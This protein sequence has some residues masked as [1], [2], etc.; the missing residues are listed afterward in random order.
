MARLPVPLPTR[1]P[2]T[3]GQ[4]AVAVL[5][6]VVALAIWWWQEN[7]GGPSQGAERPAERPSSHAT[8]TTQ[9]GDAGLPV[10]PLEDLPP[11]A[12]ETLEL[13][14]DGGPFP[15][16]R[17]GI[18]FENREGILPDEQS[19]FYREYTVPTPGEDDR[20][21]RRIVTGGDDY[22]WTEDHYDSFAVI[23]R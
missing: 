18:T 7:H 22:F 11:E 4:W 6:V 14:D 8:A 19:G 13:I 9:G 2:R 5:T 1:L 3:R 16:D 23:E 15:Y 10:V 17:D 20:G 12:E 21:A